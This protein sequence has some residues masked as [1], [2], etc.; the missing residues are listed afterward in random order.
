MFFYDFISL[1]NRSY[2]DY[3]KKIETAYPAF[4]KARKTDQRSRINDIQGQ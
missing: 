2:K 4:T 1:S 3:Q